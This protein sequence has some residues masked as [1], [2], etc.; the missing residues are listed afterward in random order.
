MTDNI[1]ARF[2]GMASDTEVE[3]ASKNLFV[4]PAEGKHNVEVMSIE[5][6]ETQQGTP[7]VKFKFRDT[8]NNGLFMHSMFLTNANYP[9]RTPEAIAQVLR[10]VKELTGTE[11][12][13]SSFSKMC[14]ELT[15]LD[16]TGLEKELNVHYKDEN[17]K[18]PMITVVGDALPF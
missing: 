16:I 13:F 3:E 18:Y 11:I 14:D 7:I 1:W 15:E 9:E 17:A 4:K 6:A 2:D 10:F 12:K 5:P 8:E